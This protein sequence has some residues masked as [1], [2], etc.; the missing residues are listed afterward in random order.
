MLKMSDEL[1][2]SIM[3][4]LAH[5]LRRAIVSILGSEFKSEGVSYTELLTELQISTGRMNY[6][7]R[8]MNGF[9]KKTDTFRYTLTPLGEKAYEA[10]DLVKKSV[11]SDLD[12]VSY[13]KPARRK[14][15][16]VTLVRSMTCILLV[17]I[18]VPV[19]LITRTLIDYLVTPV[20]WTYILFN[21]ICIG[22]GIS[23]IFWL[24]VALKQ[25]PDFARRLEEKLYE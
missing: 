24:L 22:L 8:Q 12:I 4:V 20:D 25:A 23:L 3:E 13:L 11:R 14:S 21:L 18:T 1:T 10:L 9:L 7:L 16:F 17:G 15:T 5:P 6:H 2:G 19:I